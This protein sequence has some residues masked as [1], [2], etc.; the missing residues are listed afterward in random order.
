LTAGAALLFV[1]CAKSPPPTA[2]EPEP[3]AV[4]EPVAAPTLQRPDGKAWKSPN[5]VDHPYVGRIWSNQES[6]TVSWDAFLQDLATKQTIL[7]GEKHDNADHHDLQAAI[8]VGLSETGRRP[9]VVIEM[10]NRSDEK[11]LARLAASGE[12]NADEVRELLAWDSSGWPEWSLYR[13]IFVA[14]LMNRLP[15]LGAHVPRESAKEIAG[16]GLKA[17]AAFDPK[18]VQRHGLSHPLEPKLRAGLED[19][20]FE[21]HCRVMPRHHLGG[22][23]VIQR[24]RDAHM[25]ARLEEV[26]QGS[27]DGAVLIAGSGHVRNDWA[28]PRYLKR[29]G[30]SSTSVAFVEVASAKKDGVQNAMLTDS[31]LQALPYDYVILTPSPD[32]EDFCAELKKRL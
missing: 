23:L 3:A 17:V 7:L 19:V 12:A 11:R 8:L 24:V 5:D 30:R 32:R 29:H 20:L 4:A 28:V 18:L 15:M 25:A 31:E 1:A 22:M 26:P 16:R 27:P 6:A 10:V 14:A 2:P 9:T 21:S 13:P